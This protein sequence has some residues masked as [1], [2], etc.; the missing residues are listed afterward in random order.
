MRTAK[1][2]IALSASIVNQNYAGSS[3]RFFAGEDW[4][5]KSIL[6]PGIG[7]GSFFLERLRKKQR[8][9]YERLAQRISLCEDEPMSRQATLSVSLTDSLR[10]YVDKK[11]RSGQYE[12][13]SEVIRQSLRALQQEEE[14]QRQYWALLRKKV[15]VARRAIAGGDAQDGSVFMRAGLSD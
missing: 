9:M 2:L 5:Y 8:A 11:V 10:S 13:A 1:P 7:S 6:H 4:A 14:Y 3:L 12:S 15:K